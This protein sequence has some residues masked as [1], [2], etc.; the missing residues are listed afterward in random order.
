MASE[1]ANVPDVERTATRKISRVFIDCPDP[2]WKPNQLYGPLD[3][4]NGEVRF[5]KLRPS[6]DGTWTD[7]IECVLVT[8]RLD[9]EYHAVS[10]V[11][12]PPTDVVEILVNGHAIKVTRN[13]QSLLTA[14]RRKPAM[15]HK[16]LW[17]DAICINQ[18]D[19][20]ERSDQVQVMG[21]IYAG[22][23]NVHIWV[24]WPTPA[25]ERLCK[26]MEKTQRWTESYA[27]IAAIVDDDELNRFSRLWVVQEAVLAKARIVWCGA[28]MI[29]LDEIMNCVFAL[30]EAIFHGM[31]GIQRKIDTEAIFLIAGRFTNFREQGWYRATHISDLMSIFNSV[32]LRKCTDPRDRIYGM[33]SLLPAAIKITVDYSLTPAQVYGASTFELIKWSKSLDILRLRYPQQTE[34][35]LPTWVPDFARIN[36]YWKPDFDQKDAYDACNSAE[37]FAVHKDNGELNVHAF[38]ADTISHCHPF[39][40][41]IQVDEPAPGSSD[42][43]AERYM[44]RVLRLWRGMAAKF[45]NSER[46]GL[47]LEI[48]LWR[49]ICFDKIPGNHPQSSNAGTTAYKYVDAELAMGLHQWLTAPAGDAKAKLNSRLLGTILPRVQDKVFFVTAAGR[50]GSATRGCKIGDT[51]CILAGLSWPALLREVDTKH[52]QQKHFVC[53]CY[54]DG[55]MNGEAMQEVKNNQTSRLEPSACCFTEIQ[56]I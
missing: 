7:Q 45:A 40:L 25:T 26:A 6:K 15:W 20:E 19:I 30:T 43:D 13:L 41:P 38:E 22:A 14:F 29:I 9:V 21:S 3:T 50:M 4:S 8:A 1:A 24:G 12:G 47:E 16:L 35:V 52:G 23:H 48:A 2:V 44:R 37:F 39:A 17:I 5:L 42:H 18:S 56:L 53:T 27:D 54:C 49:A 34:I 31:N 28:P 36:N 55:L 10:Y 11:W 32:Q 51:V 46:D 33:L